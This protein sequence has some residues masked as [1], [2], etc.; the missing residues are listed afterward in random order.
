MIIIVV[1]VL[2][3]IGIIW[4]VICR[5]SSG[6]EY[7]QVD[8]VI[9]FVND[10][11]PTWRDKKQQYMKSDFDPMVNNKDSAHSSRFQNRDE[12]KYCLRSIQL[13]APWIR[14]IYLVVASPSQVP[15]Y[16]DQTQVRVVLHED[17]IPLE[18]LPTFNSHAIEVNIHRIKNL[19]PIFLYLNDDLFFGRTSSRADF[20]LSN[21]KV[22]F[23]ASDKISPKGISEVSES[24]H[25]SAWKNVNSYLDR[26]YGVQERKKM[27]HSVAVLRRDLMS[28]LWKTMKP[29]LEATS[30]R[31]FRSITDYNMTCA[32]H[33]YVSLA[34]DKG[35]IIQH[36]ILYLG[37]TNNPSD[38]ISKFFL[39]RDHE[40]LIFCLNDITNE[41]SPEIDHQVGDFLENYFPDRSKY[42]LKSSDGFF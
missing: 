28:S 21:G 26:T 33:Q 15:K 11:D 1:L 27:H 32:L 2:L 34:E 13:Y 17:I 42:E 37:M 41:L 8:A 16:I 12:L 9:S 22:V 35:E 3:I 30:K 4:I 36:D 39:I 40:P 38:N 31:K 25:T 5:H 7:G 20:I 19:S 14:N 24:G 18:H 6:G 10:K 23:M 29:E